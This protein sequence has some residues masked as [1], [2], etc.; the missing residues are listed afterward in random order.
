MNGRETFLQTRISDFEHHKEFERQVSRLILNSNLSTS[1]TY[2]NGG[3]IRKKKIKNDECRSG[4][5]YEEMS[6]SKFDDL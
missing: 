6:L 1:A 2:A 5:Y 3:G 4:D